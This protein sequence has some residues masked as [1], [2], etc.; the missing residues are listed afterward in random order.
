MKTLLLMRHAKSSW[1]NPR[2]A[3]HDRPLNPRG[4]SAA[5]LMG[6][7]L[8][9]QELIPEVILCST[10]ERAKQ[11][12]EYLLQSLPFEGEVIYS[13]M[14]Y[15]AGDEAFSEEL[16]KLG[17]DI[18]IAMI[19]G[20]NPGVEYAVDNYCG[21]WHRMPT[22]AIARIDFPI[23]HW[24]ELDQQDEGELVALWRPGELS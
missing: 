16:S 7:W 8:A 3:D 11:T 15:H 5:P 17:E 14:L 18:A 2:L 1:S 24:H 13:R 20:H 12:V 23:S 4:K 22:A 19:V 9:Q 10:A 21:E 6:E